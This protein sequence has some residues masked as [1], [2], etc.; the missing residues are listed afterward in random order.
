MEYKNTEAAA[1][2]ETK[3]LRTIF[4]KTLFDHCLIK[5]EKNDLSTYDLQKTEGCCKK[6]F[7]ISYGS[8]NR[9]RRRTEGHEDEVSNSI[10]EN[11]AQSL[12]FVIRYELIKKA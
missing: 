1:D 5:M 3:Y 11:I 4:L 8:F 7:N 2:A 12:G 10:V 9:L 6:L